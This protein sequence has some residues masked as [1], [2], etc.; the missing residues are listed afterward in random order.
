M[1]QRAVSVMPPES[2]F[3]TLVA[4]H[5]LFERSRLATQDALNRSA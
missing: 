3:K 2:L 4:L 1:S 5:E